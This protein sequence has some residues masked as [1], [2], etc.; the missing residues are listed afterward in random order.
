MAKAKELVDVAIDAGVDAVKFQMFNTK[1]TFRK[2]LLCFLHE[3]GSLKQ[4]EK[5][6]EFFKRLEV[7]QWELIQIKNYCKKRHLIPLHAF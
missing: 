6:S 5:I 7:T 4:K 1:N 3:E 2:T